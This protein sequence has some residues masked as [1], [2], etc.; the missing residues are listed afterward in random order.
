MPTE[1]QAALVGPL[2]D[3]GADDAG[4]GAVGLLDQQAHGVRRQA[5]VVVAEQ[6]E[7]GALHRDEDLV[8]GGG[9]AGVGVEPAEVGLGQ[10]GRDPVPQ[11]CRIGAGGV[12]HEHRDVRVVLGRDARERLL[13]PPTGVVRDDGD[14]HGRGGPRRVVGPGTG[15]SGG[16]RTGV[17][18]VSH[19][20]RRG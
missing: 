13:E 5:H 10:H 12:D 16:A 4:V 18:G 9:E 6:V 17:F 7:G 14:D 19:D 1:Q 20:D 11:A 8:G 15:V 2:H 3:L